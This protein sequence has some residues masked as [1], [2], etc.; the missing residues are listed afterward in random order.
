MNPSLLLDAEELEALR[1]VNARVLRQPVVLLVDDDRAALVRVRGLIERARLRCVTASTAQEALRRIRRDEAGI[2]LL[3]IGLRVGR[4]GGGLDLLRELGS[5]G[6]FLPIIVLSGQGDL[7]DGFATASLN[8][9]DFLAT[10]V[11]PAY[12]L[13]L[14]GRYL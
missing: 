7:R 3:V 12:F 5:V 1:E 6:T 14:L 13:D 8:V 4:E 10:P 11:D 2:D 9:L